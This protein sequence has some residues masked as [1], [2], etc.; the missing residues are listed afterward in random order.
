M[1]IYAIATETHETY[2]HGDYG[3]ELHIC[4]ED[5]Y[6]REGYFPPVFKTEKEAKEYLDEKDVLFKHRKQIVELELRGTKCQN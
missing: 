3:T 5:A 1:K 6:H 2:G 4:Q